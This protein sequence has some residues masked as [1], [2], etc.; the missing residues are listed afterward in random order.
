MG[1]ASNMGNQGK[2]MNGLALRDTKTWIKANVAVEGTCWAWQGRRISC[3][4]GY[5]MVAGKSRLAHRMSYEA[6]VGAIPQGM[7]VRH[8]CDNPCCVNPEHLSVGTNAD[9]MDDMKRRGRQ[10]KR[11][12]GSTH[13]SS[14]LKDY[15]A[16]QARR[17]FRAGVQ[18]QVIRRHFGVWF[19]SI[20]QL[21]LGQTWK[22]LPLDGYPEYQG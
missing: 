20:K 14:R 13:H 19:G 8:S 10:G 16:M 6:F 9:N 22:H 4:Y 18:I 21:V 5:P 7:L 3:G 17:M 15:Q 12:V 2:R 11:N 1:I